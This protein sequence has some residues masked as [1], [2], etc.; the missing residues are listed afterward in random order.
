[1]LFRSRKYYDQVIADL[2]ALFGDD[3]PP[4]PDFEQLDRGGV[5]GVSRIVDCVARHDSPYFFGP[6]GFVLADSRPLPFHPC[7]GALSF[8][9]VPG[10]RP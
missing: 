8:F 10:F 9:D 2:Q 4:V 7:N 6:Y 1:M 5:V 3:A